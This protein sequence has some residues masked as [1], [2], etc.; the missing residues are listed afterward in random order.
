MKLLLAVLAF[1]ALGGAVVGKAEAS[2]SVQAASPPTV[3]LLT[4]AQGAV[5]SGRLRLSAAAVDDVGVTQVKYYVDGVEVEQDSTPPDWSEEWDSAT[6]ANGWHSVS[7]RA[8]DAEGNWGES[9]AVSVL[10]QNQ[11]PVPTV[12]LTKPAGG[13]VLSGMVILAASAS[14]DV[15]VTQVK[16]YVDGVEVEQDSTPPDWSEEWDSAGTADGWH[17][18]S[19]KARDAAGNWGVSAVVSVLVQNS[20]PAPLPVDGDPVIAAAGDIATAGSGDAATAALLDAIAPDAVLTV[21]D[22]AYPDGTL[23]EFLTY[24]EPTWGRHKSITRPTPGNHEYHTSGAFGY[25]QYFGGVAG[26]SRNGYYSY[27]LGPWHVIALNSEIPHDEASPQLA[28]LKADLA[29]TPAKCV[30]AY[31]HKPRFASGP[32][33][34]RS[35]YIPFWEAL[36]E[37]GADVVLGGHEHNY[38]RFRPMTPTGSADGTRG[39]RQFVVG[40]GG[41]S[42]YALEYDG[43]REA[44]TDDAYGVLKMTLHSSSYSWRFVPEAGKTYTDSGWDA[45]N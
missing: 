38:Q 6:V 42:R 19:A 30:L 25:F 8:R 23:A 13:A 36:Y 17:S 14:D 35:R 2:A 4:P 29:S 3:T 41:A 24:Y 18:I 15:G 9:A 7:A 31:W 32:Y 26:G 45:C 16:Y 33:G 12:T 34:D 5:L 39:I 22:N 37:A 21:G 11:G 28:W 10:V 44:G 27:D 43:R 40:T 20:G 1:G